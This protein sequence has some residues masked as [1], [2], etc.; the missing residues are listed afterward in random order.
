[1]DRLMLH[2][3]LRTIRTK[4][5]IHMDLSDTMSESI[6]KGEDI[7]SHIMSSMD[8]GEVRYSTTRLDSLLFEVN[9]AIR[10]G[11]II[12]DR[13]YRVVRYSETSYRITCYDMEKDAPE[14]ISDVGDILIFVNDTP[15]GDAAPTYSDFVSG[16][17]T[18]FNYRDWTVLEME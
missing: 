13:E 16:R 18:A 3:S 15:L 12:R 1:M 4:G 9:L 7:E 14:E 5:R 2:F 11:R 8:A 17:K 10:Q 6:M